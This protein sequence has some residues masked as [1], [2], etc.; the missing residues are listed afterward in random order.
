MDAHNIVK[1]SYPARVLQRS[2]RLAQ[3]SCFDV[4]LNRGTSRNGLQLI[5][6]RAIIYCI[7]YDVVL[8]LART[9]GWCDDYDAS[10]SK[11]TLG[12]FAEPRNGR[13]GAHAQAAHCGVGCRLAAKNSENSE[14]STDG[15]P[16]RRQPSTAAGTVAYLANDHLAAAAALRHRH[17][18]SAIGRPLIPPR[19]PERSGSRPAT[20]RSRACRGQAGSPA[21]RARPCPFCGS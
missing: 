9:V 2:V 16:L 8:A 5:V 17:R 15:A 11:S 13:Q 19:P 10:P 7:R 1:R 3:P 6:V 18:R 14:E 21:R 20:S 12:P 4:G